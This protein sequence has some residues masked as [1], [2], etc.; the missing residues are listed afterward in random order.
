MESDP[1]AVPDEQLKTS[2]KLTGSTTEV[3][4]RRSAAWDLR[5]AVRNYS[6]LVAAQVV[7][8]LFSLASVW[9]LEK[10]L[11]IDGYGGV[12]AIVAAAQA[13]QMFVNWTGISLARHGVEEFV[14]TGKITESFWA[15]T[16]VFLPNTLI[17]LAFGFLW[18]PLLATALKLPE[19]S[20]W[21]VAALF[22]ASAVWLHVQ[23]AMQAAKLPRLQGIMQAAERVLIFLGIGG[24]IL[25]KRLDGL[26]AIAAYILAPSLMAIVGLI[27]I[28]HMFS[29]RVRFSGEA[30]KKVLTFSFPLIPYSLIGYFSTNY[31]DAIFI[32]QYL[33]EADLGVYNIAYLMNG[34]IMQ[35]PLLAGSLLLPLFVTL[36][37]GGK[38][39]RVTSYL[40]DVLPLFTF[41]GAIGGVFA[42][43]L[44]QFFIPLLFKNADG[45]VII[46]WILISSAV[47]A[48][49][50]LIGFAP[51]TNAISATYIAT[52][53]SVVSAVVNLLANYL[54]IPQY[55]LK[56]CAWAT[57]LS[58]GASVIVVVVILRIR[59]SI[60]H[61]WTLPAV[62]PALGASIYA[63]A[64]GDLLTASG[65]AIVLAFVIVLMWRK[66]LMDGVRV[67]MASRQFISG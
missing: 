53:L 63:S 24:L 54:L 40:Q 9:L 21:Y 31:L 1:A 64:T 67:L 25:F 14:E 59:F 61:R 44:M 52:I 55:G 41:V 45:S 66:A 48:I 23:Y 3:G 12:I 26:T 47:F 37:G 34:M 28:R 10:Y 43:F 32:K 2:E 35:F 65:L 56:G 42:A 27:A 33:S 22:V 19:G 58:Y 7:V 5:N 30:V 4:E 51:Y 49:P 6:T 17:F 50:T 15:R 57:V 29:W 60:R 39:E 18:L 8:A 16:A 11:G 38:S 13:A 46:F 36:R 62:I 20:L